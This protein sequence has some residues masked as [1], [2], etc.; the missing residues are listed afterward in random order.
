MKALIIPAVI[1]ILAGLGGGSGYS[2]MRAA[3]KYVADSTHLADSLKAHP[4]DSTKHEGE[5]TDSTASHEDTLTAPLEPMTPADSI[6]ALDAARTSLHEETKGLAD[7]KPVAKPPV[8]G[9]HA[10]EA[11][12][13][14]KASAKP[15]P[16]KAASHEPPAKAAPR[17]VQ[18]IPVAASHET[19]PAATDSHAPAPKLVAPTGPSTATRSAADAVNNA[20]RDALETALPEARLAKI[21][22]AMQA[23]EAA[24]VLDQMNDSDVRTIL[25]MMTDKQA[26]AILTALP[27]ARAAA[28]T[29]GRAG[30]SQP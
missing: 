12:P 3:K 9:E 2:Y 17:E 30:G 7:A 26:A 20:R 28:V 29:K 15:M 21:F 27:P 1:G 6:R 23:K 13:E 8:K 11:T 22:G 5:A 4:A 10:P 16:K 14:S 19:K 24:K 18:P 25:G